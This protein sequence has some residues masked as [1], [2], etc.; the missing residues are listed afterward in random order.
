MKISQ[1]QISLFT[2]EQSTSSQEDSHVS[3]IA[4]QGKDLVKKM[5]VTSGRRCL[6]QYEKFNHDTLW[7]R[8]LPVL[9]IG[10][11]GW[12]SKRCKLIWKLKGTKSGRLYF[13]LVPSTLPTEET[14]SG[15]LP[16]P[17][18]ADGSRGAIIGKNDVFVTTKNGTPRKINQNGQN[19][20][21]GLARYAIMG[22]LPTPT[23]CDI[24]GGVTN[25]IQISQRN[26]RWIN[27]R[28]GTGTEFGAKLRDVAGL[29][30]TPTAQCEKGGR[31]GDKPRAG[32]NPLKN[33]LGDAINYIEQTSKS[34]QLNPRFVMEMM[35][36]P[37]DWTELPFLSGEM[38]PSKQEETQ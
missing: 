32:K 12:F 16:T 13:Q 19:G 31:S 30:P 11:E 23:A 1:R 37:P 20:S 26:G 9:L 29:L 10:M 24:E 27:T 36:F 25:P 22:L 3:H 17:M 38:N 34:S 5:T 15:L 7:E 21:V 33:N 6:E 4:Q 18:T 35:G 8:M 14:E 2:E 28:K